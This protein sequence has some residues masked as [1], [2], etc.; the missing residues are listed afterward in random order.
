[1]NDIVLQNTELSLF[2]IA[3]LFMPGW[4][5]DDV[6]S[7]AVVYVFTPSWRLPSVWC[8]VSQCSYLPHVWQRILLRDLNEVFL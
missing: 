7:A 8:V 1:M 5:N 6:N 4:F 2:L 3:E